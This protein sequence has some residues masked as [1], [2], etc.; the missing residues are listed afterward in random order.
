[1]S[2]DTNNVIPFGITHYC[3]SCAA[4]N[5][6]GCYLPV[7]INSVSH[8]VLVCYM[9]TLLHLQT[10]LMA[11]DHVIRELGDEKTKK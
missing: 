2:D 6:T 5:P 3:A 11:M 1:M 10:T 4:P 9:C 7:M 8:E